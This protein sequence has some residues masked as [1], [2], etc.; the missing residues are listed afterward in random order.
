MVEVGDDKAEEED[1]EAD[2]ETS[3]REVHWDV[4]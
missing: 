1:E 2:E 4:D 3:R